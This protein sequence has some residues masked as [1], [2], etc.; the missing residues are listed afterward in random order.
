MFS[1]FGDGGKKMS[2]T[3]VTKLYFSRPIASILMYYSIIAC[4]IPMC[5]YI[6]IK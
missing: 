6:L 1:V 4:G 3:R 2:N 5:E